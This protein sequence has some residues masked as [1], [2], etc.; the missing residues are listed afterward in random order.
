[1]LGAC[2]GGSEEEGRVRV[3][4]AQLVGRYDGGL[5]KGSDI[6]QLKADATYIQD[7]VRDSV[8]QHRT[9]QWHIVNH[10]FD[11]S[12]VVLTDAAITLVPIPDNKAPQLVFGDLRM[13]VHLRAGKL[14]LARNE[15][16]DWYYEPLK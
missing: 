6:L 1:M 13:Y 11:G 14:A 12:E 9:G 10:I 3:K 15:V 5:Q 4:P 16:L 2:S 8:P 7:T